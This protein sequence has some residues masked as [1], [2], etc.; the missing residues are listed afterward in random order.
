MRGVGLKEPCS[1]LVLQPWPATELLP[2][3]CKLTHGDCV[4]REEQPEWF[5]LCGE[6]KVF[7]EAHRKA[8]AS[9]SP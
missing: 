8:A 2:S 3:P 5:T 7:L 9:L 4:L 1:T 6:V